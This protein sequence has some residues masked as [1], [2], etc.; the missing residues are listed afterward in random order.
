MS[1]R[2]FPKFLLC[3]SIL[4]WNSAAPLRADET[5]AKKAS[6]K[7]A[8]K[9]KEPPRFIRITRNPD[10]NQL[11]SMDTA[12]GRYKLKREGKKPVIVELIGAVHVGR[13]EYYEQLN[14]DFKKYD[15]LL[16][17]LVA[18]KG[19]RI[20]E[21][22]R[23]EGG[24]NPV[25]ALQTLMK[26]AL[27]LDFQLDLVDYQAENFVHAD[28]SP[29]DFFASMKRMDESPIKMFFR[30]MQASLA[31][32]AENPSQLNDAVLLAAFFDRERGPAILRRAMALQLGGSDILLEALNGPNGS[33]I[34][35]ERNKVALSVMEEQIKEG[36]RKIGIFYGAGHLK[37]MHRRLVE[38]HG[39]KYLPK[40]TQWR[41]AWD[42]HIDPPAKKDGKA[43]EGK[44]AGEA[45]KAID[46]KPSQAAVKIKAN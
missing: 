43:D 32:Q 38:D 2:F 42:L 11:E 21:G 9:S 36:H 22:G 29:D 41:K 28:M 4:A 24:V 37:D 3:V 7:S 45:K 46:G 13:K 27:Q 1:G 8:K 20:P 34:I 35:T 6:V 39:F 12:I 18:P 16:Y 44:A 31:Q 15:V 5:K 10:D 23:R 30:L 40:K 25:S 19:T 33:T 17:E 14:E 26:D